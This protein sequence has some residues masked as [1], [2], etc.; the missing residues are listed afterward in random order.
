MTAFVIDN[1]RISR[2]EFEHICN[3]NCEVV[4]G[5]QAVETIEKG[6]LY[7][8]SK[9]NQ[10]GKSYYGINTGFGS[11]C[12]T[13]ISNDDL[14]ELQVNLVRSHACGMGA[15][16]PESIVKR[17]LL[18]KVIALSKGYSGVHLETVNRLLFFYNHSILPIVYEQG[19]LGASGDL[20]PLAHLCLPLIGEGE[21]RINGEIISGD[22]LSSRFS[23]PPL[24]LHA[25]EG[26]ALLNGTQFMAAYASF[27]VQQGFNL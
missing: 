11:L 25:K 13:E 23:I 6:F 20:A 19:S 9:I 27:S 3:S 26:L 2:Q 10:V 17:M 14:N 12:N 22:S 4:L 8:Q 1:Q 7:L 18:L 5:N 21:V 15:E 16:V 24:T